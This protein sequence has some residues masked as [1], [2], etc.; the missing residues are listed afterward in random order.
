M[1]LM[2][3]L[4]QVPV[5]I[6]D[7]CNDIVQLP[8]MHGRIPEIFPEFLKDQLATLFA[9]VYTGAPSPSSTSVFYVRMCGFGL[10]SS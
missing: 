8:G 4:V 6:E 5:M 10:L 3:I 1:T 9:Q 7:V 2:N